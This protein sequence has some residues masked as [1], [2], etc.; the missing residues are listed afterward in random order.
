L[1][2][3]NLGDLHGYFPHQ[4]P[5]DGCIFGTLWRG[6]ISNRLFSEGAYLV[7][8]SSVESSRFRDNRVEAPYLAIGSF[9]R[10]AGS[11]TREA[12]EDVIHQGPE[13]EGVSRIS[14]TEMSSPVQ[15]TS[16]LCYRHSRQGE[17]HSWS[18]LTYRTDYSSSH[19]S[20]SKL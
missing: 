4:I 2:S 1:V 15:G 9:K 7:V 13:G 12:C 14:C 6:F 19:H 5:K 16:Y 18:Y 17:E 11:V 20:S 8:D 10:C 3:N